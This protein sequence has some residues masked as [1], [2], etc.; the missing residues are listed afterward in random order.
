MVVLI[1]TFTKDIGGKYII[2]FHQSFGFNLKK[3]NIQ[4]RSLF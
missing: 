4:V 1:G 2:P 3:I